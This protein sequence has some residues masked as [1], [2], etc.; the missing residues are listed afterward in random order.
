MIILIALWPPTRPGRA[1]SSSTADRPNP[2][3]AWVI[4]RYG[5]NDVV[6]L[7]E[8]PEPT[9]RPRDVLIETHAA[10]I[11]PVDF[12]IRDGKLKL[13]RKFAFP[14]T[15]GF[16]VSGIVKQVGPGA[17]RFKPGDAV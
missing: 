8:M 4:H 6:T 1:S 9:L 16:D 7:A 5:G 14:L 12:K 11:N 13:V 10:S 3:K 2:M 17:R 15:L